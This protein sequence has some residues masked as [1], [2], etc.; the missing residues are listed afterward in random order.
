MTPVY[1]FSK[2]RY[3]L[4]SG[5]RPPFQI[6]ADDIGVVQYSS[7][8]DRQYHRR[9]AYSAARFAI[10]SFCLN[11]GSNGTLGISKQGLSY[12]LSQ[13]AMHLDTLEP[14]ILEWMSENNGLHSL[15][16][17]LINI[18]EIGS[19]DFGEHYR[20]SHPHTLHAA[21]GYDLI[22][23]FYD[24]S[25]SENPICGLSLNRLTTSGITSFARTKD[26]TKPEAVGRDSF[27]LDH[28]RWSEVKSF[29]SLE[30]HHPS[31]Y[32]WGLR[33]EASWTGHPT[34]HEGLVL[35]RR[36]HNDE[37]IAYHIVRKTRWGAE[38]S[39]ISDVDARLFCVFLQRERGASIR[40]PYKTLDR[41]HISLPLLPIDY[42]PGEYGRIIEALTWPTD[43]ISYKVEHIARVEAL[44]V[45]KSALE[46]SNFSLEER[47]VRNSKR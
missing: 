11:D 37:A 1:H 28:R 6:I 29:D 46:A 15:Y 8:S 35:A 36:N 25:D 22:V 45:I 19:I 34:W 7:E 9:V 31:Q 30:F 32:G 3:M 33:N 42:M 47:N 23:G 2:G 40:I 39:P 24:A 17:R 26:Q 10:S 21:P 13:W 16:S 27:H 5:N 4:N 12:R 14:G 20:A 43:S 38:C 41:K 18:G 44:P